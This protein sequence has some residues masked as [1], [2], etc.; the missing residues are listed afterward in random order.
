[1]AQTTIN[2]V[3]ALNERVAILTEDMGRYK[4]DLVLIQ[5]KNNAKR[6]ARVVMMIASVI[7]WIMCGF[8]VLCIFMYI[9]DFDFEYILLFSLLATPTWLGAQK[10]WKSKKRYEQ[11][12]T[13]TI[14]EL[15]TSIQGINEKLNRAKAE[16]RD[17]LLDYERQ[18]KDAE[19]STIVTEEVISEI[20]TD[21]TKECPMCAEMVKVRAKKCRFCAHVFQ[22]NL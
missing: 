7:L 8:F 11:I 17:M 16:K 4:S 6:L 5:T 14:D 18:V 3:D 20:A 2:V 22:E 9:V 1:M 13:A 21:G 12:D 19:R 15:N 10:V